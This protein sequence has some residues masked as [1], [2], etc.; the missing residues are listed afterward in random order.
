MA[1]PR[2]LHGNPGCLDVSDLTNENCIRR[3]A[4]KCPDSPRKVQ[5]LIPVDLDLLGPGQNLLYRILDRKDFL[6]IP[7]AP[8]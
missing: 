7:D 5:S 1:S 3:L 6:V 4:E 8:F 2:R